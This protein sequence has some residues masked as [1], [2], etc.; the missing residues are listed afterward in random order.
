MAV[1]AF[2]YETILRYLDNGLS[3]EE[4]VEFIM[5]M[6][7]DADLQKA[8]DT[9]LLMQ[10]KNL[11]DYKAIKQTDEEFESADEHIE[12]VKNT[13]ANEQNEQSARASVIPFYKTRKYRAVAAAAIVIVAG[14]IL[15]YNYSASKN[16]LSRN[17]GK[18]SQ[19][20]VN[21]SGDSLSN[22][23]AQKQTQLPTN[24]VNLAEIGQKFY[25]RYNSSADDPVE[26]SLYLAAYENKRY[27][28]LL[29][30]KESDLE[31]KGAA[32]T[33]EQKLLTDYLLFYKSLAFLE[34]AKPAK[35]AQLLEKILKNSRYHNNLFYQSQWYLSMSYLKLND[36]NKAK[37]L[38]SDISSQKSNQYRKKAVA[39]SKL[40][41]DKN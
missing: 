23:V 18:S 36:K 31:T 2:Q 5:Q 21:H 16:N 38:I 9:E 34:T 40:L 41:N 11:P 17:F 7:A 29:I 19:K 13:K 37:R 32:D 33:E 12:R 8:F 27:D 3:E 24:G 28:E 1:S 14:S 35:A 20:D 30:A 25:A 6:A 15:V 26:V 4:E 10:Q 22:N 39:I